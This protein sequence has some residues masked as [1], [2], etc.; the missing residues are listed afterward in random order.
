MQTINRNDF[1]HDWGSETQQICQCGKSVEKN[2][3]PGASLAGR[4]LTIAAL[5]C[6]NNGPGYEVS[7][8]QHTHTVS[9]TWLYKHTLDNGGEGCRA[10]TMGGPLQIIASF[11]RGGTCSRPCLWCM[12]VQSCLHQ[13]WLDT[14]QSWKLSQARMHD[15]DVVVGY[16]FDSHLLV[17]LLVEDFERL[18]GSC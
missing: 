4:K 14:D 15:C 16:I 11:W 10:W 6:Y 7:A 5:K 8:T 9:Y 2:D 1:S 12:N 18:S 17:E 3:T 13:K